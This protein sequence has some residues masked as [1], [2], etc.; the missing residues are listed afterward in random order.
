[1]RFAASHAKNAVIR[2]LLVPG[3][4]L[5]AMTTREPDDKQLET[6]ISALNEVIEAKELVRP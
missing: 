6:A 3:L 4:A 1:M 2:I 5:Q